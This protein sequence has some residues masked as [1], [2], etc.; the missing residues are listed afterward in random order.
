MR[1]LTGCKAGLLL[2]VVWFITAGAPQATAG[3]GLA[4]L[5]KPAGCNDPC[6]PQT[7]CCTTVKPAC[8]SCGTQWVAPSY[9]Y[10]VHMGGACCGTRYYQ[11]HYNPVHPYHYYRNSWYNPGGNVI[12]NASVW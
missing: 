5:C 11:P 3:L 7:Q 8:N 12:Y 10:G 4:R 2:V 1:S 6:R 9:S